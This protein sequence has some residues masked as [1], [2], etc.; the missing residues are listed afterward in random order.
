MLPKKLVFVDTE[1]TGMNAVYDRIIEIGLLCVEDNEIVEQY[2]TLLNPQTYLSPFIENM[3]GISADDLV[4]APTF[5][6]VK[7]RL[8]NFFEDSVFVA[9]NVRFDYGFLK[10]EFKR[11][12]IKF[13][14]KHFCTVKLSK[15]LYPQYTHHNLDSIITRFG[16]TISRRHRAFD[17]AKILW[18]FY[19]EIQNQFPSEK[20]EQAVN[21]VLKKPALPINLPA[22]ALDQLPESP[23]VYIFYG[24]EEFLSKRKNFKKTSSLNTLPIPLYI[25]KSINIRERVLSHFASDHLSS[26][27]MRIA[28]QITHIETIQTSGE[29]GALFKEATLVKNLQPLYNRKLRL[30][31]K[32]TVLKRRKTSEGYDTVIIE[33]LNEITVKELDV[34]MGIFR[35]QKQAKEFLIEISKTFSLCQK[36]FGIQKTKGVCFGYHLGWCKGACKQ[37]ENPLKY[38]SRFIIAFSKYKIKTWPFQGPIVIEERNDE[39]ESFERFLIDKWCYLGSITSQDLDTQ[40]FKNEYIFDLDTYKILVNYIFSE[41]NQRNIKPFKKM[42]KLIL[43]ELGVLQI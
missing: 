38:N 32:L 39:E 41:K 1:T 13:S 11:F 3:T 19:Q 18:N 15:Y 10:N 31:H 8:R 34:V 29:L 4:N 7:E 17:D 2:Q 37:N 43:D 14:P 16:F 20:I 42:N 21:F 9:H 28:Q 33:T 40:D 5:Y 6:D 23:G 30:R 25:G 22:K 12:N 26:T 24:Q 27:E 36:L 35:S